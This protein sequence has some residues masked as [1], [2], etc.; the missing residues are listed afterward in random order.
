MK[1]ASL[2]LTLV[3][4]AAA[5]AKDKNPPA[6]P[7]DKV[8]VL[9]PVKI[10]GSPIISF[11]IDITVYADPKTKKVNRIFVSHVHP[12]SDAEK[13]G[14]QAGDEIVKLDG[15]AVKELD[16]KVSRDSALGRIFLNRTPGEP[17]RLEALTRRP[18]QFVIKAQRNLPGTHLP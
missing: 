9:E 8:L 13:A 12:N 10:Q 5:P 16:S 2:L 17:L 11:A 4:V 15:V 6:P 3:C 1:A 14:L 18:Q 7:N